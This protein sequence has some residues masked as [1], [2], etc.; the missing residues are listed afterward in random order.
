M[1][2]G[3]TREEIETYLQEQGIA[4]P[5]VL[6]TAVLAELAMNLKDLMIF[7]G[8]AQLVKGQYFIMGASEEAI[9]LITLKK[10]TGKIN[11][12]VPAIK[13]PVNE[14]EEII[15]KRGTLQ[16]SIAFLGHTQEMRV[17][18]AKI[19]VGAKFHGQNIENLLT[20][21]ETINKQLLAK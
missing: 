10:L 6:D 14:L 12:K 2:L 11:H 19:A 16:H 5:S 13:I 15:V 9:Y 17:R 4:D 18:V 21:L 7:G 8:Y 3:V 1:G 20:K